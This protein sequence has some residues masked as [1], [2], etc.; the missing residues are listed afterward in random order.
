MFSGYPVPKGLWTSMKNLDLATPLQGH[1]EKHEVNHREKVH[2]ISHFRSRVIYDS[3]HSYFEYR[4]I[5]LQ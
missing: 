1:D 3:E 2:P 5:Q 4:L